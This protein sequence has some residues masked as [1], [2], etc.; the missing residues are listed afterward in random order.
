MCLFHADAFEGQLA[1]CNEGDLQWIGK[2]KV[3]SLPTWE[4]DAIFLKLFLEEEK[5]FFS[6]RLVYEGESLVDK[7]IWFYQR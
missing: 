4:G 5:R 2:E 6:L 3:P 1:E 7:K